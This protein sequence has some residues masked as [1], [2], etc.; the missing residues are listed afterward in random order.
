MTLQQI[1]PDR[2]RLDR[3]ARDELGDP[4]DRMA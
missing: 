1:N 3:A 4:G 2:S